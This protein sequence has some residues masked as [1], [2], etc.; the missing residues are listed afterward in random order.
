MAK[1]ASFWTFFLLLLT[2]VLVFADET[3]STKD[4]LNIEVVAQFP[5]NPFGLIVNGQKNG[6][7]LSMTNKDSV[8]ASIIAVSGKVTL[9]DDE[10]KIIRNLT[11]LRYDTRLPSQATLEVPYEFYSEFAPGELGLTVYV[12]L[13]ADEKLI[14]LVGYS[15]AITVTDPES[16]LLDAQL[17]FLYA[18]LAAGAA[19]V[20]YVVR[21]AFFG[22]SKK[23]PTKAANEPTVRAAHRDEKGQMVL[24]ESWIPEHHLKDSPKQSPRAKKRTN[25]SR[26]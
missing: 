20:L 6:V 10:S 25:A 26:K 9:V 7:V 21:E 3:T 14:R 24:D 11:A 8:D 5:D 2:T 1:L 19:G 23:T 18:I 22:S 13:V 17:L 15:G 4:T 12:D 16:S